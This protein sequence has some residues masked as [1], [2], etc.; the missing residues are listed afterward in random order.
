MCEK[1]TESI[2]VECEEPNLPAPRRTFLRMLLSGVAALILMPT[3]LAHAKKVA[4]GL[5]KLEKLQTAGGSAVVKIKDRDVLL[6]RENETTVHA[7]NPM[8]THK[9]CQVAFKSDLGKL[10]CK[11][12][13]SAFG[14]DGSVLGGPAPK[15]LQIYPAMLAENQIVITLP[16]EE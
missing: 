15:P 5:D 9:K 1:T 13:K 11:C 10:A 7:I 3:R 2:S 16:D 6:V 12:H 14:L 4:V 8:C